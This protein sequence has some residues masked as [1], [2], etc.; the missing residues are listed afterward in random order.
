MRMLEILTEELLIEYE[1][2][3]R[4]WT[5]S[6][7]SIER[8]IRSH[9][10]GEETLTPEDFREEYRLMRQ[11]TRLSEREYRKIAAGNIFAD[12]LASELAAA[13]KNSDE[14]VW[15]RVILAQSRERNAEVNEKLAGGADFGFLA[16]R[17]SDHPTGKDRGE[18]GW[19]VRGQEDPDIENLAFS[20]EPGTYGGPVMAW[21]GYVY[22]QT[23]VREP[24]RPLEPDQYEQVRLHSLSHFL[25]SLRKA[26][27]V[28]WFW[29][30]YKYEW[31]MDRVRDLFNVP[32]MPSA[33]ASPL[34]PGEG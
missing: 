9:F 6:D 27:K 4:G 28:E 23:V 15:I 25:S 12:R 26:T 29:D 10:Q 11:V 16:T 21:R 1:A 18:Y 30:S 22:V 13:A 31:A 14:Q 19:L 7:E 32:D 24:N 5:A 8:E 17:L 20:L 33:E 2:R 3:R 34:L